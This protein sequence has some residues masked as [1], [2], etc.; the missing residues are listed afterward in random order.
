METSAQ[1]GLIKDV[2]MPLN[3][4]N[5]H[6][7][8][9]IGRRI[10]V[11]VANNLLM[12]DVDRDF[13]TPFKE[14]SRDRDYVGYIGFGKLID[15]AV[16]LAV[17]SGD[18]NALALK[19][20]LIDEMLKAREAD[21]YIGI[22]A[23]ARRVSSL[24]DI[25]EMGY[26]IWGL[27]S[28]YQYF[29][30]KNSLT[31]ARNLADYIIRRWPVIPSNWVEQTNIVTDTAVLGIE[32]S[33]LALYR[34]TGEQGYLNFVLQQR[35]LAEWSL[36]IMTGR[37][38]GLEGHIYAYMARCLAQLELHRLQP[39]DRLLKQTRQ[40]L[41]FMRLGD[42]ML[43]TGGAGLCECW[44]DDQD[45][46]GE[47]AETCAT[48]YQIRVY[49][50]LLRLMGDACYGDLMER[51]IFNSLFAAQSPDGRRL[52]YYAPLEGNR[53]YH[54]TDTYCC[55]CNYRRIISELPMM[56]F[57][58]ANNGVAVNLYTSA[59]AKLSVK[60]NMP[61][62][63]K[64]ETDYP[65]SGLV[66][67]HVDPSVPAKFPLRLRIPTWVKNAAI[68]ING[69]AVKKTIQPGVFFEIDREWKA[70]DRVT[71]NMPMPWRFV[72]GRRRQSG[73]AAVMRGPQVFCLNPAQHKDIAGLDGVDVGYLT[74]DPNS[75]AEPARNDAV[76]PGGMGCKA[77]AWK[78]D[79]NLMTNKP[80][81]ELM[82]TEFPDPDGRAT[83][84]RFRD[85]KVAV[86]D[87]LT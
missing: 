4:R 45:G 14:K 37:R 16:K 26:I 77:Q 40:A 7:G 65:S 75:L 9:E 17:Y 11:T 27:L 62:A 46:R 54:N 48:A 76:R 60:G 31:A 59:S 20:H 52:R 25:H 61:V 49:D 6:V 19:Q 22:A 70:G 21:G 80:N 73:R 3:L 51:T 24:W 69:K 68:E 64:Q 50:S 67:L 44:T 66:N 23:P 39:Q 72:K 12:L 84:F 10:D 33:M 8:G 85:M 30:D 2:F 63:I 34:Q 15:A 82:L 13:L 28:D 43:V 71:L 86:E 58:Q 47:I 18:P 74:L 81:L 83:Y 57:Y 1:N 53:V 55:P 41:D 79:W 29:G 42:G 5:V 32:R 35:G 87:E 56:L 36:G 78:T 38:F